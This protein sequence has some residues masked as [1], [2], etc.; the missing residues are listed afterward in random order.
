MTRGLL[1][2]RAT[3][4]SLHK[5]AILSRNEFAI[6]AYKNFRNLYNTLL[7]LSKKLYYEHNLKKFKSNPKK[8]WEL[9]NEITSRTVKKNTLT[10]INVDGNI[11][12]DPVLIANTFND[13]FTD[14]GQKIADSIPPTN[15][16]PCEY[17]PP[18]NV[19]NPFEMGRTGQVH[20]IDII[21]SLPSK[22]SCDLMGLNTKL[23]KFIKLEISIPLAHIFQ[24]S[25]EQ[26]IFPTSL[27]TSRTVPIFKAGDKLNIDNYRPISLVNSLSKILEKMVATNLTNYLQINKLLS[28]WQFGF[29]RKLNTEQN[30]IH[31]LNFIGDAINKGDFCIGIFFDLR[32]AFDVVRHD[33]LL[34]KL[35]KLG[36]KGP[37]LKW[38]SSYLSDR[39]QIVDINGVFSEIKSITCSVLQ[40]SILGPLLFLCF[41]N[42]FP[43]STILKVL[44]FADDTTC[45][46]S[47]SNL[48]S[49]IAKLNTEI[50]KMALWYRTNKMS[51]NVSKTKYIIFHSKGKKI[52]HSLQVTY[53]CNEPGLPYNKNLVFQIDRISFNNEK[54][55][56]RHYKLLGIFL[57]EHLTF[58]KHINNLCS[59]LSKALYFLRSSKNFLS[60]TAL[61]SLY[62]ALF[63]PHLLYC[64]SITS[65]A[66]KTKLAK[67]TLLQ[68]KAIRIISGAK[69]RDHTEEL[70]LNQNILPFEKLIIQSKLLFMHAIY[71]KY[72]HCS[73]DGIWSKN[74][75]LNP[76]L[77][78]RN[79]DDIK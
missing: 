77:N 56:E 27:K 29:Q 51:V 12:S 79:K 67:I 22:N 9:L 2:S 26:G 53:D 30:L 20:I 6:T 64:I 44:M 37:A 42:D 76:N 70:F 74:S 55:D 73:F 69:Y 59:K 23:L 10:E 75:E 36:I 47:G 66:T 3:K 21:K 14:I 60:K 49:L 65:C 63:H 71:Y 38:F 43:N 46:I 39:K 5:D 72:S 40:G 41:I 13:F 45:L 11:I 4:N 50:N 61:R 58:E 52:N 16:N 57:D 8:T 25:L 68:K 24:K 7:R 54:Q 28:P 32:K 48:D 78:L 33:V 62:F 34:T 1:I 15:I 17:L 31:A 35:E 18:I 19:N